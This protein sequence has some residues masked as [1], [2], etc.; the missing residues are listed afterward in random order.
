[1]YC[2]SR[3][4]PTFNSLSGSDLG[5][6][7]I[8]ATNLAMGY[9]FYIAQGVS[10]HHLQVAMLGVHLFQN[11]EKSSHCLD[12]PPNA[13][14]S[15]VIAARRLRKITKAISV[16]LGWFDW[17]YWGLRDSSRLPLEHH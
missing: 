12:T 2:I 9:I 13:L 16:C 5:K 7:L 15:L 14:G 17:P 1:M 10:Y 4:I 11:E 6:H 3:L 8:L